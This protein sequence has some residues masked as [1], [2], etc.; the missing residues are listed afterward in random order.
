MLPNDIWT[1]GWT[2][3]QD[4]GLTFYMFLSQKVGVQKLQMSQLIFSQAFIF[5]LMFN[6]EHDI[7]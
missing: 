6:Q 2:T 5:N 7:P 1:E 3:T 4:R